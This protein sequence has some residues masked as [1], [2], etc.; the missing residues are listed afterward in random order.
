V[1]GAFRHLG[2]L[3]GWRGFHYIG[4]AHSFDDDDDDDDDEGAATANVDDGLYI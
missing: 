2:L 1:Q 3:W 4:L